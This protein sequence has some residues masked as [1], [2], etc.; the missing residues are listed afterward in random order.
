MIN[1]DITPSWPVRIWHAFKRLC[2]D[3]A[4]L[5]DPNKLFVYSWMKYE[6]V[7]MLNNNWGDDI[8]KYFIES[9][10]KF[11]VKDI[12]PSL[13]FKLL[14]VK[15][16]SCIGSIIGDFKA[17][18]YEVWGSGVIKENHELK[19]I[20]QKVHSVRGPLTRKEL[21]KNGIQCPENYGDPALLISRYYRKIVDK[22]YLWGIIPHYTDEDNPT[23]IEFC[24]NHP[25]VLL[26][27]MRNYKDWH[28]IPDKI[29]NC[30]RIMSSSLH[31]LII[32]DS[33]GVK[34]VWLRFSDEIKGGDFKYQ[35]YFQSVGRKVD[36][37]IF[38]NKPQDLEKIIIEDKTSRANNI[39]FKSI[40]DACPFR[41]DLVDYRNLV[42]KLPAY[43]TWEEKNPHFCQSYF[44]RTEAE[45]NQKLWE[46]ETA[47][48]GLLFRGIY[49]ASYK[50][51]ASSQRHWLQKSDRVLSLGTTD[52]YKAIEILIGLT[53]NCPEVA[54]YQS[55]QNYSDNDMYLLALMQHFGMP[56]PMIDF[57]HKMR[58]GLFFAVDN[59]PAWEDKGTDTPDDYVSLYYVNKNIDWISGS[60]QKVMEYGGEK[61]EV[62]VKN[63]IE[64][65]PDIKLKVEDT[66]S[67]FTHLT[68]SQFIPTGELYDIKFLPVN[69]ADIG[70]SKVDIPSLNFTCSYMIS[71]DRIL[72]QDGMFI[73]NNTI[74]QPL[75]EVMNKQTN[76]RFVCCLNIRKN[77]VP[78]IWDRHLKRFG[79]THDIVYCDDVEDVMK[80]QK[81]MDQM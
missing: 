42:P 28:E 46:L 43:N 60:A 16:Y 48:E 13:L 72:A 19:S 55:K 26:I 59:M 5:F 24:K 64:K 58:K 20:P 14:P 18:N 7:K 38:I 74:D 45:L 69:G 6:G 4:Y 9:I 31:G 44:V 81:V 73:L 57:S 51:Y 62:L 32:A 11:K 52:Y 80:L 29:M 56:S 25:D 10:S 17:A 22:Q 78:Y 33:Y 68:Y 76:F 1:D 3:I 47:E 37:P 21:L 49:D 15:G 77:L 70:V 35:D 67:N 65:Y 41:K 8:N 12:T 71:N 63:L 36:G 79:L 50:M 54:K 40:F 66:L 27:S 23:I 39:N 53:K 34:N 61:V 75:V 2:S 30:H